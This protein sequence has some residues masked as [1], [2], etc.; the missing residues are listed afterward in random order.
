MKWNEVGKKIRKAKT[1]SLNATRAHAP[2][3]KP[4]KALDSRMAR[5]AGLYGNSY[6]YKHTQKIL[7]EIWLRRSRAMEFIRRFQNR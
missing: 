4:S 7:W 5:I 3:T 2:I 1:D 6:S